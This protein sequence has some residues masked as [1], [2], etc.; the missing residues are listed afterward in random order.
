MLGVI[1]FGAMAIVAVGTQATTVLANQIHTGGETG[2]YHSAFCPLLKSQLA[3]FGNTFECSPSDGTTANVRRVASNPEH[4]A[5]GQLDAFTLENRTRQRAS[6]FQVVRSNDVREC[7][8]AVTSNKSLTNFGQLAVNADRLKFV[9]P[10]KNSGSARTFAFLQSVDP[11]GLG[12]ARRVSYAADTDEALREA[13]TDKSAVSFFVQFPD[14]RNDRFG[15]IRRLGGHLIPVVDSALLKERT[16][17]RPIY[18]VQDTGIAQERRLWN[19]LGKRV[20]TVC[21]PM[22][23]FTGA[24]RRVSGLGRRQD[25]ARL[26]AT[27]RGLQQKDLVPKTGSF[28]RVL[29]QS[30]ELSQQAVGHFVRLSSDARERALPFLERAYRSAQRG[31]HEMILKAR[32]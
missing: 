30:R 8:F 22:I 5:F 31:I 28:S 24:T 32:P 10:P 17:G 19:W 4:F 3:A 6:W 29:A 21:T 2:A 9:L 20:V 23:L 25:H 12:R 18:S 27:I 7:V 15:S 11:E 13:L 1:R 14:P 16:N 26:V